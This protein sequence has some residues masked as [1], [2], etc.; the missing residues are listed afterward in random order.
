[1][2]KLRWEREVRSAK[3]EMRNAKS[4]STYAEA[5][6]DE[7]SAKSAST[8][9]EASVDERSAKSAEYGGSQNAQKNTEGWK[10]CEVRNAKSAE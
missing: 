6:G 9:A 4:A 1:M 10:K 7:R 5:S 8:Y 2:L 3:C